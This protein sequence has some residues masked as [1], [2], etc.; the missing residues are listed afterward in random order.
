MYEEFT[1]RQIIR[2]IMMTAHESVTTIQ[3]RLLKW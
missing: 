2:C 1:E 3:R